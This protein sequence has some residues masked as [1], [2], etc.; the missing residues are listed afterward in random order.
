MNIMIWLLAGGIAGWIGYTYMQFNEDRGMIVSII[1]GMLGGFFGGKVLAPMLGAV[2]ASPADFSLPG[3][4]V[5]LAS[6]AACL[7]L[8]NLISNR[9]GI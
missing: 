6:A 3:V 1:I 4:V 2:A 9:Y 8:G 7:A 5:A